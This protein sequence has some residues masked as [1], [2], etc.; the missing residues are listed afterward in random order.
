MFDTNIL[1]SCEGPGAFLARG[2][3]ILRKW[4]AEEERRSVLRSVAVSPAIQG[5]IAANNF[6][7]NVVVLKGA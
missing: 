5:R 2:R 1:I 6:K 3:A 4:E 7:S